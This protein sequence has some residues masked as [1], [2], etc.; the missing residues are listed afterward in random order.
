MIA[1]APQLCC[2]F[3]TLLA[4][5]NCAPQQPPLPVLASPPLPDAQTLSVGPHPRLFSSCL[6]PSVFSL[7]L[8]V[9]SFLQLQASRS[10]F[11]SLPHPLAFALAPSAPLPVSSLPH[12]SSALV[13][14]LSAAVPPLRVFACRQ[15]L[16]SSSPLL[17]VFSYLPTSS[18][19]SPHLLF[20][21]APSPPFSSSPQ[22]P[23][24]LFPQLPA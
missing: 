20:Y 5:Q 2:P 11:S 9:S 19:P 15:P 4:C 12:L 8:L 18:W 21:G 14:L 10:L 7:Q 23:S 13:R 24:S 6:P 16:F 22:T 1:L 17:L 3:A